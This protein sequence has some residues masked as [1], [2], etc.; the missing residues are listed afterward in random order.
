MSKAVY[1]LALDQGTTSTRA[2][3]FD[4]EGKPLVSAQEP[5]PQI[6]PEPGWVEHDPEAIWAGSVEVLRRALAEAEAKGVGRSQ[7]AALGITNQRETAVLWERASLKPVHNAIV[8]QD[9]RTA[10]YCE[11]LKAR[12]LE[13]LIRARTGLVIDPYFSA[14]K[15]AWLLEHVPGLRARAEAGAIAFGTV[16]SFLI[17]RLTQGR[18][19]ATDVTNASRTLLFDIGRGAWDD[20]LLA[21]F[22]VPRALLPEARQ[23]ADDYGICDERAFGLALPI[24]GVVG[25]QQAALVGQG[26][27][28]K[29][30]AKITFGTGA[31]LLQNTGSERVASQGSLL[32]TPAFAAR[33]TTAYALEGSVFIAGAVVQWLRDKL[34][35]F[36]EVQESEALAGAA[37]RSKAVYFVPAFTGLGAPYWDA[38]AR[39]AILGLTRDAGAA[40]IVRAALEGVC[41]QVRDL[42]E[43][44][45]SDVGA[46]EP[47]EPLHADGAMVA[48]GWFMQC[49]ADTLGR[50]IARAAVAETTA[51]GA[52]LLAGLGIGVHSSL[53]ALAARAAVD[54]V[55]EPN[56]SADERDARYA[57]WR[58][59]VAR[60]L[61]KGA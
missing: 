41:F 19:H 42:M 60:V 17:A 13:A 43:A 21:L 22:G 9:R 20:E 46:M 3:V 12:G 30:S 59:A 14:S 8:W 54:R 56:M 24:A 29:G 38:Q 32:T 33:G 48:N 10:G 47:A 52:A 44:I 39:G 31:F 27:L 57:G 49:L 36:K 11:R 6:F 5:L 18:V 34:K 61:T 45:A 15:I 53:E 50:P 16:D 1:L 26:C 28:G 4:R 23:S 51:R 25:D 37:D 7:I 55:F 40:E 58:A 2:I 35:L